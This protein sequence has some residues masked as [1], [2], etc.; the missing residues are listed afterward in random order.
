MGEIN[1]K[2]GD[3]EFKELIEMLKALAS[4]IE[5]MGFPP[6]DFGY[7]NEKFKVFFQ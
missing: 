6:K 5:R 4:D 7:E 1:I 3:C 2:F